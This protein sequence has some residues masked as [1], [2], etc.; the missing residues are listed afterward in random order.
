RVLPDPLQVALLNDGRRWM[1]ALVG[2]G[3]GRGTAARSR[4][5]DG[6]AGGAGA[7]VLVGG[8]TG[9]GL[10]GDAGRAAALL[11]RV[12]DVRSTFADGTVALAAVGLISRPH[13]HVRP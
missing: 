9:V 8:T 1:A 2:R 7:L 10:L 13:A 3:T 11:S 4:V 6:H 5:A 12:A